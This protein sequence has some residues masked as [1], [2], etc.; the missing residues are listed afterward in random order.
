MLVV[1]DR[2]FF[3]RN[4][5]SGGTVSDSAWRVFL[6]EVVTPRL[7]DGFSVT[8]GEGQWRGD[9]GVIVRE[10]G[11]TLEV[12]HAPGT[13]PDSV[14]EAIA[15]EYCRRFRQDAVLR[16][17]AAAEEWLYRAPPNASFPQ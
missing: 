6:A 1:S 7:P 10:E 12:H 14:F 2:L 4:I 16:T 13:P 8:R 17:R 5:R 15:V 3:G 11:F 9:D